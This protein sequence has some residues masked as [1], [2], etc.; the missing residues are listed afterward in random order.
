MTEIVCETK[1]KHKALFK[2]RGA[3]CNH[4]KYSFDGVAYIVTMFPRA[5]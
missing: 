3:M 1:E 2:I 5:N 4:A